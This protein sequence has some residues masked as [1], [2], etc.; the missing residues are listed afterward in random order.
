MTYVYQEY[1]K[2]ISEGVIVNSAEEE[3]A[4]IG[5]RVSPSAELPSE[6]ADGGAVA[7]IAA[8]SVPEPPKEK[9]KKGK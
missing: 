2:W 4:I 5:A 9:P 6:K 8:P 1:P 7:E 3:A